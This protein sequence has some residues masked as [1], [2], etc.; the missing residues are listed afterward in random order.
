MLIDNPISALQQMNAG[1]ER[2]HSPVSRSREIVKLFAPPNAEISLAG[3]KAAVNFVSRRD[4]KNREELPRVI[5]EEVK[6]RESQIED[7]QA[8]S[9][10][11]RRFMEE[12]MPSLVLDALRRAEQTP[13][14]GGIRRLGRILVQGR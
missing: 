7:L 1:D 9:E 11:H 13:A 2:Q 10:A 6:S 3:F 4:D 8:T 14:K 12:E 5:A